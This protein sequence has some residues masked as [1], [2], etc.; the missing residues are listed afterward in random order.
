MISKEVVPREALP[1]IRQSSR[2]LSDSLVREGEI[3]GAN[4]ARQVEEQYAKA[5]ELDPTN[6]IAYLRLGDVYQ[7]LNKY[8]DAAKAYR[9]AVDI[10]QN[11]LEAHYRLG[12]LY[13]S[14]L[15]EIEQAIEHYRKYLQLGGSDK[16]VKIWL[17]N[18]ERQTDKKT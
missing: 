8:V 12:I 16:R 5:V 17:R 7:S 14:R 9:K 4:R 10:S 15:H 2:D 18:A 3:L 11:S 1:A 6:S 13:E